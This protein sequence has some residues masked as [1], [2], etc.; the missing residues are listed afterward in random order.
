MEMLTNRG[1]EISKKF[2]VKLENTILE[3]NFKGFNFKWTLIIVSAWKIHFGSDETIKIETM[4][5]IYHFF[6]NISFWTYPG[7][8]SLW[9]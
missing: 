6:C 8:N 2:I 3:R 9:Y 1:L 7:L 5:E 4:S